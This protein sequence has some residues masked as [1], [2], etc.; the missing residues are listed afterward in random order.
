MRS[1]SFPGG[2]A[3]RCLIILDDFQ[4]TLTTGEFVSTYIPEYKNYGKLIKEI[5]H[6]P[7]NSCLLLLS[8]EKPTE[9]ANLE[10]ENCHCH[11]LQLQGLGKSATELL[12]LKNLTDEDKWL[13]LMNLYSGNPLWLN[14]IAS[15]IQD[16]FNG[17]VSQFLSYSSLFLGDLEPILH[18]HY[19][20]L[21]ESEKLIM[22]WL[23]N[24]DFGGNIC[25]KPPEFS[26]NNVFLG[27][28]Q[29]LRKLGLIK[30]KCE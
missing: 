8:W 14:I 15:T 1:R 26:G 2:E 16:L 20:R 9:I 5:A 29:S 11:T 13:K 10:T 17:R 22:L 30:K 7:H 3:H 28:I 6:S 23:A 21:S 12:K 27:A 24:Q 19:R 4:E 18:E 25:N